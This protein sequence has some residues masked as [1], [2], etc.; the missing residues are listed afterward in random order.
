MNR[1]MSIMLRF[2]DNLT[3]TRLAPRL[4]LVGPWRYC[5]CL[6]GSYRMHPISCG[7]DGIRL[8]DGGYI[9]L[10]RRIVNGRDKLT[11]PHAAAIVGT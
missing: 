3:V 8:N 1:M 5:T 10:K 11:M 7:S 4:E 6:Y 2:T 9:L